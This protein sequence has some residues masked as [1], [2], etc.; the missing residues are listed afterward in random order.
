MED[1]RVVM[2]SEAVS[3]SYSGLAAIDLERVWSSSDPPPA[4][5]PPPLPR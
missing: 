1:C 2:S 4:T 3:Y 5:T